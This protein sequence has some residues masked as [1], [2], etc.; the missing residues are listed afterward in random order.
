LLLQFG[1]GESLQVD[2]AIPKKNVKKNNKSKK[3]NNILITI[4]HPNL[5]NIPTIQ[6]TS[7]NPYP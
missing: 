4:N 5:L 1:I 2:N 7:T 6:V 3:N